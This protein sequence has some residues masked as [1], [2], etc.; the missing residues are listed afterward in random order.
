MARVYL[1]QSGSYAFNLSL[2]PDP[3]AGCHLL[4]GHGDGGTSTHVAPEA[5]TP[6]RA[7][8][9]NWV[10][11]EG[12]L[13]TPG[14]SH[15]QRRPP[16]KSPS[17]TGDPHPARSAAVPWLHGEISNRWWRLQLTS[18][19]G[20]R[21]STSNHTKLPGT[22]QTPDHQSRTWATLAAHPTLGSLFFPPA[23]AT[24]WLPP[25]DWA[26][27]LTRGGAAAENL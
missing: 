20:H 16:N 13:S 15:L 22:S 11:G 25:R 5:S 6:A 17:N 23:M 12:F 18:Q 4:P 14:R 27:D 1:D 19:S 9:Q 7:L 10:H 26:W 2:A 3:T 21:C 24:R 8:R